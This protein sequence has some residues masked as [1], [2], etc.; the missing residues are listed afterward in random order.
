MLRAH[1]FDVLTTRNAGNLGNSD[2]A[3]FD[4]ATVQN[5]ALLTHNRRDFEALHLKALQ[6]QTTHSGLFI[7]NRHPSD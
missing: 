4:F 5:R 1:G 3:Q 7:A 2:V 6:E